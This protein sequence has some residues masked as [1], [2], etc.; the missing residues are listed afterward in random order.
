MIRLVLAMW[1]NRI[2]VFWLI[3]KINMNLFIFLVHVLS[4]KLWFSLAFSFWDFSYHWL[5]LVNTPS[6]MFVRFLGPTL[7]FRHWLPDVLH[8][9]FWSCWFKQAMSIVFFII[10]IIIKWNGS[11]FFLG[12]ANRLVEWTRFNT[13]F[14]RLNALTGKI[15]K[16]LRPVILSLGFTLLF[17]IQ[18]LY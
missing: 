1:N 2:S 15:L 12:L 3:L 14:P 8:L 11:L 13:V 7:V 5:L 17:L 18:I 16:E 10:I 4:F 9:D 6:S